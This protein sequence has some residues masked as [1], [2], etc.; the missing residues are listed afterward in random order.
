MAAQKRDEP[1]KP[2]TPRRGFG[3]RITAARRRADLTQRQA[4][5]EIGVE[6][7][8]L[9]RWELNLAKPRG[10]AKK[11]LGEFLAKHPPRPRK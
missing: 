9:Q 7:S 1:M 8:T 6:L 3:K 2:Q 5:E 10:L 4:A 11:A